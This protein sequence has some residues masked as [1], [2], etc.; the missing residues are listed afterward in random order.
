MQQLQLVNTRMS[1]IFQSNIYL[2]TMTAYYLQSMKPSI[3]LQ[4]CA[5][6]LLVQLSIQ[7]I[8]YFRHRL[9][10]TFIYYIKS[11]ISILLQEVSCYSIVLE[12]VCF[13][14]EFDL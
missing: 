12:Q 3:L 7:C 2:G 6:S 14:M 13:I 9:M 10:I 4:M 8:W 11:Y 5:I 1:V